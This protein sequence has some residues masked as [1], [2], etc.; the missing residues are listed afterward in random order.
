MEVQTLDI[1]LQL[2]EIEDEMEARLKN[3]GYRQNCREFKLNALCKLAGLFNNPLYDICQEG[4]NASQVIGPSGF[5]DYDYNT[6]AGTGSTGIGTGYG[7][8]SGTG[9][10]TGAG[11]SSGTSS[12]TGTGTGTSYDTGEFNSLSW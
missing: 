12:G 10:D 6:A 8:S 5:S 11:T 2:N 3:I 1:K 9:G 4:F 7:T